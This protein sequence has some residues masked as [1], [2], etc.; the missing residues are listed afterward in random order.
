MGRYLLAFGLVA[1]TAGVVVAMLGD[2]AHHGAPT[3][4]D[5]ALASGVYTMVIAARVTL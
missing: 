3:A 4:T 5:I 2:L 1:S